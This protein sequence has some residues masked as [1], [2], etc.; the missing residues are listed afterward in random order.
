[1][2]EEDILFRVKLDALQQKL[3]Q[4]V[5]EKAT[6]VTDEDV[7][8][9]YDK[10]KKRFAQ[11]ERRDLTW[12]SPRTRPRPT[13]PR[14]RSRTARASKAVAKKYSIDEASKA[15][16]GKLPDVAKGQ[17]EKA[18]D[19]AIFKAKKG[20]L[21]GPVKTQFG[22]YV[23]EVT[24]VTAGLAAVARAVQ[25]D[26]QEPAALPAPAEGARQVHQGLP[27]GV[28]GEDRLRRGLRSPSARTRR[29]RRPTPAPPR[30]ARPAAAHRSRARRRAPAPQVPQ[31]AAG[32]G[33]PQQARRSEPHR[34]A[35][36]PDRARARARGRARAA[37]RD[38]PA[39]APRVPV[40]PRA[41]RAL[42][43][44]RT[45]SR[46]PTSWPTRP[47]RATTRKLLDELGD[48]LFQVY[49]LVAAAGGARR[50]RPG[51]GGRRLPREADPPPPARV[52]RREAR[53]APARSIRNWDQIKRDD[54]RG[55]E[56]FG[57]LPET[58]P[59]LYALKLRRRC[60]SAPT[61]ERS[62][63]SARGEA[64][65]RTT[66]RRA[67]LLSPRCATAVDAGRRPRA[68]AAAAR[69]TASAEQVERG[70]DE[71]DRARAR[72]PDPRQ[73]RQPH[74]RGRRGAEVG[75]RRARG[76]A[77]GRLHGRV[78]GGRAARRRRRL[79]RQGRDAGGGERER[80]DRRGGARARRRRPGRARP[81]DDR[82]RRHA[83]T[84]AGW[85]RTRSSAC[86]WP[87]PRRRPR[88]RGC[89]CGATSAARPRTCCRCR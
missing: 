82:A 8:A 42:D 12:C 35:G 34:A 69:P 68:R 70:A 62:A 81:G 38:H 31:R 33:A 40:G 53:D 48:V 74:R 67:G 41:G 43:R 76:G 13:R 59:A 21:E 45:R 84:R 30:A 3:T 51:R 24:K 5:T 16:G 58:L 71:R 66:P 65:G 10:N 61:R 20:E 44:A 55:G 11:P 56:I 17:Q 63:D 88:R 15:Q 1:M 32:Q 27:R 54:E 37:R 46:R 83:A 78:R 80:R 23:F 28:Q 87:R 49:F 64:R 50:G 57:E 14:R 36:G 2:S 47:T 85:A 26:D 4:K 9:Y 7:Q 25:G 89:R 19:E 52:R 72:P 29:R 75:R 6:K 22:Y 79:G 73:P 86:R 60:S 39:A 77:L 18:F